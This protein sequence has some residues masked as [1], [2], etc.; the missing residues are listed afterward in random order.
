MDLLL[1]HVVN[2]MKHGLR[3]HW[4]QE[5]YGVIPTGTFGSIMPRDR[6]NDIARYIHVTSNNHAQAKVDRAWKIRTV[7]DTLQRSFQS[8]YRLGKYVAY[9]EAVIPGRGQFNTFL[10]YFKDKPHKFGTKLFMVCCGTTG[11]CKM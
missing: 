6:F 5:S 8:S 2:P 9:D 7:I 4:A 11:Y 1:A 10:M 3:Y